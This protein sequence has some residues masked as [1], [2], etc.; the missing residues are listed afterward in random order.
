M[1]EQASIAV[2]LPCYNE[3]ATIGQVV[4]DFRRALP[5]ARILVADNNS[6]DDTAESARR[7]G[8]EVFRVLKQGK[9]HA[10]RAIFQRVDADIYVLADGDGTYDASAS[11]AMVEMVRRGEADMLV[12]RRVARQASAVYRPMHVLGNRLVSWLIRALFRADLKDILSGYRVFSREVVRCTPLVSRGFEIE[13]ELTIQTLGQALHIIEIETVYSARPPGSVSKLHTLRDGARVLW[14]IFTLFVAY[15]PLTFFGTIGLLLGIVA[16]VLAA[17]PQ[18]AGSAGGGVSATCAGMSA[19]LALAGL[20]FV[21]LGIVLTHMNNR[22]MAMLSLLTR[23]RLA[24][25]FGHRTDRNHPS[26]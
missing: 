20:A 11:Q 26:G 22:V 25:R 8:A 2:V 1:T 7:S 5:G 13:T 4:A 10:V 6:T 12:G 19:V 17:M 9:G 18:A 15:K 23:G 14:T 3:A 21:L 16:G 24:E